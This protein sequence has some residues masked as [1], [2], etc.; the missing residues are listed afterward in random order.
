MGA[1]NLGIIGHV[2]WADGT[3][4]RNIMIELE[5]RDILFNDVLPSG[6]TDLDGNFVITYHP[7]EYGGTGILA[8][9]PDIELKIKYLD[10]NKNIKEF[11][12]YYKN[13]PDEWLLLDLTLEDTGKAIVADEKPHGSHLKTINLK[14]KINVESIEDNDFSEIY[15][16]TSTAFY[17]D[18]KQR[19]IKLKSWGGRM[20]IGSLKDGP[21]SRNEKNLTPKGMELLMNRK[22]LPKTMELRFLWLDKNDLVLHEYIIKNEGRSSL[23]EKELRINL[24]AKTAKK[25]EKAVLGIETLKV[26]AKFEIE[27]VCIDYEI[28]CLDSITSLESII[29]H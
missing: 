28:I 10:S 18:H 25:D 8:E 5:E 13:V 2:S 14:N 26:V 7:E 3:P 4:A 23:S 12:K 24:P 6:K 16:G 19:S 29:V 22:F 11:K 21:L 27:N 1:K 9:K 20:V 17:R 15:L